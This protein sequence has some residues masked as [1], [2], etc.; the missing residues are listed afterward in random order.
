M[1]K[2]YKSTCEQCGQDYVGWGARFCSN[3]CRVT[4]RNLTDNPAKRPDVKAKIGAAST[5]RRPL[6]GVPVPPER[7]AKIAAALTGRRL[8]A[9]HRAKIG[10]GVQRAGST[11]PRNTHLVGP[12][13]PNWKGGHTP[14][15]V[16]DF[17]SARYVAYRNAVLKRDDWTCQGCGVRGGDLTV[18][19]PL[20]WGAHPD[21]RYD[22]TNGVTLCHP[23]HHD[24]H[25]G[26][27]RPVTVVPR[28]LAERASVHGEA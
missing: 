1:P 28:T 7:R 8:T 20:S 10:A 12:V 21:L 25:R 17:K 6:L 9:D 14:L 22:P 15:R 2:R 19:H 24:Q 5:G 27:P 18:H 16:L 11:P 26:V 13:H 3:R 23:C 4:Q